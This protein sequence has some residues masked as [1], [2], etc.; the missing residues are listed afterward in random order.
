MLLLTDDIKEYT[1]AQID[2][3][4]PARAISSPQAYISTK[5]SIHQERRSRKPF[6]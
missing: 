5:T 2:L 4:E 6:T 1:L 3:S